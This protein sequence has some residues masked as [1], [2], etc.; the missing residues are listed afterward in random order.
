MA[1]VHAN[2]NMKK[3][4][5]L[6]IASLYSVLIGLV[7]MFVP[8][9]IFQSY[10]FPKIADIP[11]EML[12]QTAR[13]FMFYTGAN[14]L[15]LGVLYIMSRNGAQN[16]AVLLAGTIALLVCA[17]YVIY[18]NASQPQTSAFAWID[19]MVRLAIGFGFLY[20]YFKEKE[21]F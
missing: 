3:Q 15:A 11:H 18:Q 12:I 9:T 16:K 14:A 4:T 5:F 10:G 21:Q 7:L 13:D 2:S 20:Y 17:V 8:D 1:H 19:M 6:T